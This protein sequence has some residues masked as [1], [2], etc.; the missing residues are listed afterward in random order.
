MKNKSNQFELNQIINL[1]DDGFDVEEEKKELDIKIEKANEH[2]YKRLDQLNFQLTNRD[3]KICSLLVLN[4]SSKEIS[5][6]LNVQVAS[7]EKNRYRLRKKL[8]LNQG[9][10]LVR[11]LRLL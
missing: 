10:D 7:V 1:I 3:K 4:L 5:S 11:Y 8:K 2:F 6:I 9:D